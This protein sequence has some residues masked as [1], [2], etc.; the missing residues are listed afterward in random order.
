MILGLIMV[1][2]TIVG[3]TWLLS[4][5]GGWVGLLRWPVLVVGTLFVRRMVIQLIKLLRGD[6]G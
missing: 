5:V 1:I 3:L 4:W 2:L 6:W